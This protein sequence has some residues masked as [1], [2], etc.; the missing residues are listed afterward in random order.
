M[1]KLILSALIALTLAST[2]NA[3][4]EVALKWSSEITVTGKHV[5]SDILPFLGTQDALWVQSIIGKRAVT[6]IEVTVTVDEHGKTTRELQ[7]NW[8]SSM[9]LEVEEYILE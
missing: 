1:K 7:F 8:I 6:Y 4:A 9:G 3:G 5:T 2:S